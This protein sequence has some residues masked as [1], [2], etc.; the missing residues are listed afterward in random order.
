MWKSKGTADQKAKDKGKTHENQF[1]G[2]VKGTLVRLLKFVFS[3]T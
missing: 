3:Q 2:R 1:M